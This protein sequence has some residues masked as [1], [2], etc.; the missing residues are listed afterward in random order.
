MSDPFRKVS[1]GE[2]MRIPARTY[3]AFID[4]AMDLQQ[5][6][7][8]GKGGLNERNIQPVL[9]MVQNDSGDDC[10]EG[11]VLGIDHA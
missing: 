2:R 10:Q 11:D 1:S 8:S 3:N 6:R 4:A 9:V 5:R 7:M